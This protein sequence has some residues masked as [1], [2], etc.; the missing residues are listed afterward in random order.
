MK[1]LVRPSKSTKSGPHKT[2]AVDANVLAYHA[3]MHDPFSRVA[4]GARQLDPFGYPTTTAV[5]EGVVNVV[6]DENGYAS[7][8]FYA[9][10]YYTFHVNTGNI[11]SAAAVQFVNNPFAWA[12]AGQTQI[13]NLFSSFRVVGAGIQVRNLQQPVSTQGR[14]YAAKTAGTGAVLPKTGLNTLAYDQVA[15]LKMTTAMSDIDS[16]IL[17][18]PE[19][20]ECT[21]QDL[22]QN[23]LP[24]SSRPCSAQATNFRNSTGQTYVGGSGIDA[25]YLGLLTGKPGNGAQMGFAMP[26]D[27]SYGFDVCL[28]DF[29]GCPAN[30]TIAEIKYVIHYEGTPAIVESAGVAVPDGAAISPHLPRTAAVIEK[31]AAQKAQSASSWLTDATDLGKDL[32]KGAQKATEF[33]KL[34]GEIGGIAAT[35]I[36]AIAL[37]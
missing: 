26:N 7:L 35:T 17:T 19:S 8:A 24:M 16:R 22:I 23:H 37:L 14:L 5:S 6:T 18:L 32:L 1:E 15:C 29:A 33:A 11:T 9:D 10:P 28:L 34:I 21:L 30:S 27:C 4:R 20:T 2:S 13:T 12:A 31:S 3:V 36:D 25:L